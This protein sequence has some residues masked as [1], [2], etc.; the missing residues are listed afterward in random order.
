MFKT[1]LLSG[2]LLVIIA[3]VTV[4]TGG[5]L[6]FAVLLLISL[7]GMKELYKVFH[8]EKKAP[9]IVGYIF[10]ILYYGL[11]YFKPLLPGESLNCFVMLFMAFLICQMAVLVFAYPKYNTQQIFAGFF[12]MFYVAVMLSYIYQTRNLPGGIFSVWLVFVCSWGCDT[13]AYCVG[14]LIGKHKMAPKLSPK[15]S[16]EG[17]IGGLAGA[18]LLGALYALAI[19][20]WGGASAGVGE[21]ALICFVGGIISMIGDLAASAIKR[22]HEIKDY[23]KLIPGHGGILD[24][25]DSVIFTAPVIYYLAVALM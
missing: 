4:I 11:L 17:G 23:G 8:I 1:R 9:G 24:R 7:I 10:A 2:I 22:N 19:N 13:C 12:G 25:F 5:N 14:V 16:I 21:Y 6:L 18:A 20:K 3:L 15:K